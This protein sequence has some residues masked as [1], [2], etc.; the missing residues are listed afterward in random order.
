[1]KW[2]EKM[3]E[4]DPDYFVYTRDAQHPQYLWVG[5]SDAR[6]P[7]N[8]VMGERT[9]TVFVHRNIANLVVNTDVNFMSVLQYAVTVLKVIKFWLYQI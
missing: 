4:T 9:D 6:V 2:R 1:M 5:C 3:L 7:A 8:I